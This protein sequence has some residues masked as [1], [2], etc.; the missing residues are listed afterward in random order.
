[1]MTPLVN[2][3]LWSAW[4]RWRGLERYTDAL[5]ACAAESEIAARRRIAGLLLERVQYFGARPDALPE[6]IEAARIRD[7]LELWRVWPSLPIVTK[8]DLR[9]RFH[10]ERIRRDCGV[11]GETS[12]TGG[13]T[14]EPTPYLHDAPM[15]AATTATRWYARTAMGWNPSLAIISVWGSERDIGRSRSPRARFTSALRREFLVDGYRLDESTVDRVL[16]L[17]A[18]ERPVALYGF[19]SM[20][21]FVARGVIAKR[22]GAPPDAV[23]LAWSGGETL[24]AQQ[25]R[26][27]ETAFGVPILNLYGGRELSVLG[28]E[29]RPGESLSIPRPWVFLEIVD[30]RGL[31]AAPGESGRILATSTVCGGTPFLRYEIGDR[32][33]YEAGDADA[34]G[35]RRLAE[36]HGRTAGVLRLPGGRVLQGIFWNH[37]FKEYPEVRQFQVRRDRRHHLAILLEGAGRFDAGR[38]TML[39]AIVARALGAAMEFDLEWRDQLP[40]TREGKLLQVVDEEAAA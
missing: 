13:S 14:G 8:Q 26:I 22:G 31:P 2:R 12:S 27:F 1:M 36:L 38:E 32:G 37:L 28:F 25:S 5:A 10:P 29:A 34:S 21:E 3:T 39:R 35:I 19:S 6:W 33:A 24:T 7:P 20:L 16:Q 11:G 30:D 9:T 4:T 15:L 17:V 23:R 40:R 18:S